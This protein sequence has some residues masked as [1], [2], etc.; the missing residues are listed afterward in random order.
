M[1]AEVAISVDHVSKAYRIW[2]DPASRLKSPIMEATGRMFP[3]RSGV[4]ERLCA[5]A[6]SYYRDFFALQD[7]SFQVRKGESVGIIGRNGSGKSTL[8]Q[9]IAGT[10][11]PTSGAVQVAGRVAALLEL[12]SGF[13]PEFTG[14]ENVYMNAAVLGLSRAETDT[15]FAAIASFADIGEFLDQPVKTYSSGM[16][17]R[18]AFAVQTAVDPEVLIVDEALSV[19]DEAFQRKCFA[20]ME[21]LRAHGTTILLVTHAPMTV[22]EACDRALLVNG[23]RL[24]LDD[25]PKA[26]VQQYHRLL[27]APPES[28]PAIIEEIIE[29]RPPGPATAAAGIERDRTASSPPPQEDEPGHFASEL[30]S[31]S[32]LVYESLGATIVNPRIETAQGR[33]VNHLQK[34]ATYFYAYEVHFSRRCYQVRMAH[35]FK[36]VSGI[37]LGGTTLRSAG[38]ALPVVEP[39]QIAQVRI[40]FKC[41]LNPGFYLANAGVL[42]FEGEGE[43]YLHRIVDAVIFRVLPEAESLH[44][45]YVDLE[46]KPS[47]VLLPTPSGVEAP[48]R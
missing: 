23:G 41:L 42:A 13:N 10:L 24:L 32:Q 14:R 25:E 40:R 48:V 34:N 35:V 37:E 16:L 8:L 33:L 38:F 18:L 22:L 29:A 30:V 31:R 21:A 27:F 47:V 26:V 12:G 9:I 6:K 45:C 1:S 7:V 46:F 2:N 4:H 43:T 19:G 36:T 20:R 15:R 44:S 11:Q 17:M 39:G 3:K 5:R 28:V